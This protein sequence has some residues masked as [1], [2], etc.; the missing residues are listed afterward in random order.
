MKRLFTIVAIATAL[1]L[2]WSCQK[3][4]T[5][6]KEEDKENT[7]NQGGE[8][9]GGN[10]NQGT[11][12]AE[13]TAALENSTVKTAWAEGDAILV[14]AVTADGDIP[15]KYV[16]SSGA[17]TASAKFTATGKELPADATGY[18]ATY[19]YN[20][21][22][23][24]AMH[25]T[26][27]FAMEAEQKVDVP[28]FAYAENA[29]N[30]TFSSPVGAVKLSL[31]GKGGVAKI[32]LTDKDSKNVLNGNVSYNPAK[33]KFDIKN[34]AASKNV[35]TKV[36]AD[37]VELGDTPTEFVIEVPAGAYAT[38][39]VMV[40]FDVNNSP[41]ANIEIPALTVE[42]GKVTAVETMTIEPVAQTVNLNNAQGYANTYQIAAVGKY[43]F[44]TVK[45][46]DKSA[47]LDAADVELT[48]E[49][50]CNSEPVTQ[51]SLVKSLALEDG[52][53][54]IETTDPF[55]AGNALVSVKNAEGT[56]IWSWML[57]FVEGIIPTV[58]FDG[59]TVMD[60]NLG[61]LTADPTKPGLNRGL[62]WQWGRIAP[63][64]GFDETF[65]AP[66]TSYPADVTNDLEKSEE[67]TNW[68]VDYALAH[69]T[70]FLVGAVA[71]NGGRFWGPLPEAESALWG[72]TKTIYD[73]CPAGYQVMTWNTS[74]GIF[75]GLADAQVDETNGG[76]TV[77]G[78]WFPYCG[79]WKYS[80]SA[81]GS[82]K[83]YYWTSAH[84]VRN[85]ELGYWSAARYVNLGDLAV[86]SSYE[87]KGDAMPIRCEVTPAI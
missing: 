76:V 77:N 56:I 22:L 24:F 73:P 69:P 30:L 13:I 87:S 66:M 11:G 39:A 46:N 34:V 80:S 21:S 26:F 53:V 82:D 32:E 40:L 18:F 74:G 10:E 33:G 36:L 75:S 19:P 1:T 64:M 38:G 43:K 60:R 50:W 8:N 17:G 16:L 9:E 85:E 79:W 54:V 41:F 52:Y 83:Q 61:A 3:E 55:C 84:T 6:G 15:A 78:C 65:E 31:A 81:R 2:S 57:W 68:T 20:E 35:A 47:K 44:A 28:V 59:Q 12:V 67:G 4:E 70:T 29:A 63:I 27:A 45:G 86:S 71:D 7:G 72:E 62:L 42:A 58:E 14:Y 49:T 48:W 23:T 5:P 51:N 25:N 37:K